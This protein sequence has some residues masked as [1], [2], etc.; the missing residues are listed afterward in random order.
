MCLGHDKIPPP[1]NFMCLVCFESH[2]Y[3]DVF[4]PRAVSCAFK[5]KL[6]SLP[7]SWL[8]L[9]FRWIKACLYVPSD[10][11]YLRKHENGLDQLNCFSLVP[12]STSGITST[13]FDRLYVFCMY[14]G[15]ETV[16]VPPFSSESRCITQHETRSSV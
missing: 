10:A 5:Q 13:L 8:F 7:R 3:V 1:V 9:L 16:P 2:L 12:P 6:A 14:C 4:R 11:P 15:S